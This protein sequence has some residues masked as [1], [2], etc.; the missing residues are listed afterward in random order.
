MTI[1]KEEGEKWA[2]DFFAAFQLGFAGNNHGITLKP[3]LAEKMSWDWSDGFSGT[4]EPSPTLTD[5]FAQTWGF[6]VEKVIA[7]PIVLVSTTDDRIEMFSPTFVIQIN[8]GLPVSYPVGQPVS[9]TMTVKDGKATNWVG[10]WDQGDA[11][12]NDAIAKVT[13]ALEAAKT[14]DA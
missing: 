8:G 3:F 13:A 12:M 1:T 10:L 2:K 6:M 4:D 9:F 14:S 5:K 11:E 7:H